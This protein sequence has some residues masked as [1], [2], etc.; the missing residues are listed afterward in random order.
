MQ[1]VAFILVGVLATLTY[2]APKNGMF[3]V[4]CAPLTIQRSDPIISPGMPSAHVH[5]IIGGNNFNRTMI[6]LEV[7]QRAN[8]TTCNKALDHSNYW[9]PQLYYYHNNMY[10]MVE[11]Q[12]SAHYYQI[13]A[14]DYVPGLTRCDPNFVPEFFPYGFRM[15]A[16]DPTRRTQNNTDPAQRAIDIVC[17]GGTSPEG[18]GFPTSPCK[19]FRAQV[20]FPSC[21][22]GIDLDP[23]N[24]MSHMAY[25]AFGDFNGGVCPMS[26]PKALISLFYEFFFDT[27]PF[28]DDYTHFA[29]ANGDP[30]GYGY[31]GDFI[32]GWTD[33]DI[34]SNAFYTCNNAIDCPTLGNQQPTTH[35]LLNPAPVEDIGL[36]GPI[37]QLPGNNQINWNHVGASKPHLHSA[38][39]Q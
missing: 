22:N 18:P 25:P 38:K 10:T 6:G 19:Q 33:R 15:I 7:A 36:K 28:G 16:G 31:H 12:G 29:W 3:T 21:W 5:A 32:M 4:N 35:P 24:H 30:T 26:H 39:V 27:S 9:V 17:L 34:V 2:A 14:C 37:A 11:F 1:I 8:V 13:R 23:P 20:Y